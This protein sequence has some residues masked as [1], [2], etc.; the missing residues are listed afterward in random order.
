MDEKVRERGGEDD[1]E[2]DLGYVD[3]FGEMRGHYPASSL[4]AEYLN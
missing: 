2:V 3:A 4:I 1:L